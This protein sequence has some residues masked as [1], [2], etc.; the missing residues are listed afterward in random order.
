MRIFI[1]G[2][3]GSGKTTYARKLAAENNFPLLELDSLFVEAVDGRG[4]RRFLEDVNSQL[5]E[6][7]AKDHWVIEGVYPLDVVFRSADRIVV[8][9]AS[10][11]QCLL[12]IWRRTLAEPARRE[13]YG[14]RGELALTCSTIAWK[15]RL[16]GVK[17]RRRGGR[18]KIPTGTS[19][20]RQFGQRVT[21][22]STV[23]AP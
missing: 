12:R 7:V 10:L 23:H 1:I 22:I 13:K 18:V 14:M 16:H 2:L 17:I 11:W 6:W 21:I 4:R 3:P 5:D 9:D 20:R 15:T 8:L 19:L